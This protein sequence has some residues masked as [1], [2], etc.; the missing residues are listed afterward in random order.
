MGSGASKIEEG[1]A[2]LRE[3]Q[4]DIEAA[5]QA[6]VEDKANL[7]EQRRL[8]KEEAAKALEDERAQIARLVSLFCRYSRFP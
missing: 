5:R 2:E 8:A 3:L 1:E 4:Q 6:S 7:E